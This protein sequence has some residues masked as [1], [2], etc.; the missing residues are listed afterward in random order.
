MYAGGG[1]H[2]LYYTSCSVIT[3]NYGIT[4]TQYALFLQIEFI[5][6]LGR[7]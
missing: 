4:L 1:G 7:N 3:V 2:I 6:N 5:L